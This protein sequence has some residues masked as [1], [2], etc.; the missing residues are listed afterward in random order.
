VTD[1]YCDQGHT[2]DDLSA[3]CPECG[4]T[5]HVYSKPL[6]ATV[7]IRGSL[8]WEHWGERL[9][10]NRRF[11]VL[12]HVL[13]TAEWA[14]HIVVTRFVREPLGALGASYAAH[15]GFSTAVTWAHGQATRRGRMLRRLLNSSRR[16]P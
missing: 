12:A 6:A 2:L 8:D 10:R 9:R 5:A 14:S 16:S 4:S 1:V 13:D 3:P 11:V 15:K 7:G